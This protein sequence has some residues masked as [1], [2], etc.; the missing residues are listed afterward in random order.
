MEPAPDPVARE[1]AALWREVQA[2]RAAV[3]AL[4]AALERQ[5]PE[6][7]RFDVDAVLARVYED[8][9]P[10]TWWT[11]RDAIERGH[12]ADRDGRS[13]GQALADACRHRGGLIGRWRIRR[14]ADRTDRRGVLWRVEP[15]C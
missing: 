3:E 2:Q 14:S 11:T 4:A 13:L 7:H 5:R 12:L 9:G 15:W 8:A 6:A 10:F 1:L